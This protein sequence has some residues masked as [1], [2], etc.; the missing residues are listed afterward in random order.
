M[1]YRTGLVM[2][3][4]AGSVLCRPVAAEFNVQAV[5]LE[6]PELAEL[7]GGFV[8]DNLEIAIGL[9]QIVSVNGDTMV[10]NRLNIPNLNQVVNGRGIDH[11]LET[12]LQVSRPDQRAGTLVSGNLGNTSGWMTLVQN[13]LDG[14]VIQNVQ[15]LNIELNNIGGGYQVPARLNEHLTQFPGR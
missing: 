14:T 8:F 7:R 12:V 4:L 1:V 5:P 9:E 6:D 2:W 13:N 15:K 11:H 10:V 3:V